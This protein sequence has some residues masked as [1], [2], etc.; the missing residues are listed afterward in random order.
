MCIDGGAW[1]VALKQLVG[2]WHWLL[3][4]GKELGRP[5]TRAVEK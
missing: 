5:F 3:I 1:L 4:C 2:P